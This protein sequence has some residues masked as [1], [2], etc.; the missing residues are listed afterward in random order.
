MKI[1]ELDIL[2]KEELVSVKGGGWYYDPTT[3]EWHWAEESR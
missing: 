1:I 2:S 3:D